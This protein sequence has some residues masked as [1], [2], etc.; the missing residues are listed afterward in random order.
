M[1]APF[2]VF[3]L[4]TGQTG[5]INDAIYLGQTTISGPRRRHSQIRSTRRLTLPTRLPSGVT[6]NSVGY[7]RIAVIV[8]PDELHQRVAQE[9]RRID[10]R[11]VHRPTARQSHD[12]A[13]HTGR[14]VRCLR[15]SPGRPAESERHQGPGG[16]SSGRPRS[17]EGGHKPAEEAPPARRR[18]DQLGRRQDGQ[19][20]QGNHQAPA[21]DRQRDLRSPSEPSESTWASHEVPVHGDS[22]FLAPTPR[23][24]QSPYGNRHLAA[25]RGARN[26]HN[27]SIFRQIAGI[28]D[29]NPAKLETKLEITRGFI[30]RLPITWLC[31]ATS[32]GSSW[33]AAQASRRWLTGSKMS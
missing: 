21:S 25:L 6:L 28:S 14:P 23:I 30:E 13:R 1:P 26:P 12:R 32:T 8:D 11:A 20:R 22:L 5:S 18:R 31:F 9:Q 15:S 29:T 16:R 7:A 4:L 19:P 24:S 3:F 10:L 33:Q 27:P 17:R 2:Q